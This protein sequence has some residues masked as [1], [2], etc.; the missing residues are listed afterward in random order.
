MRTPI[1]TS[2]ESNLVL[3]ACSFCGSQH[4]KKMIYNCDVCFALLCKNC[5]VMHDEAAFEWSKEVQAM[6]AKLNAQDFCADCST[7]HAKPL[8]ELQEQRLAEAKELPYFSKAY[9]GRLPIEEEHD[10]LVTIDEAP[11]RQTLLLRLAVRAVELGYNAMSHVVLKSHK[12]RHGHDRGYQTMAWTGTCRP[13]NADLS[14][15]PTEDAG[16]WG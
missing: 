14:R 15:L 12:V 9:R 7:K 1:E 2:P 13:V 3:P 8:L 5:V 4:Y 16:D 11:D 6:F 10:E